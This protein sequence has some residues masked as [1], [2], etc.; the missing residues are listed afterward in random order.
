MGI[1]KPVADSSAE[2]YRFTFSTLYVTWETKEGKGGMRREGRVGMDGED[3]TVATVPSR[4]QSYRGGHD[5][6]K[7]SC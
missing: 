7:T 6:H 4:K 1:S 2:M 5:V 3:H